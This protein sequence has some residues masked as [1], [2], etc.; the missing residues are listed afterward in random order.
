MET[1][2]G[3]PTVA[4]EEGEIGDVIADKKMDVD[5]NEEALD[6]NNG[7]K[8]LVNVQETENQE[9]Q[10]ESLDSIDGNNEQE[11]RVRVSDTQVKEKRKRGRP[12]K[13]VSIKEDEYLDSNG[14]NTEVKEKRKRGRPKKTDS[15]KKDNVV[16]DAC[17]KNQRFSSRPQR[18]TT[19]TNI[20]YNYWKQRLCINKHRQQ[21]NKR[22]EKDETEEVKSDTTPNVET[23]TTT[24]N[25]E[26]DATPNVETDTTPKVKTGRHMVSHQNGIRKYVRPLMCHQCKRKDK[27]RVVN[28][29]NCKK[30]RYCVPCMTKWYP[31]MTE[32]MFA[33]RCPVC[34]G[35][36]NCKSCLRGVQS[37][38]CHQC[39]HNNKG[40]V[41][42]CGNCKTKRYCVPCMTTWY[43]NMTEEMFAERC[44]VCLGSCN[45]KSCLRDV[46]PNV[47]RKTV[48]KQSADN[49]VQ[50]SI[51]ILHFLLPFL[52]R[53][54]KDNMKEKLI[55]SEV[56]GCRVSDVKLKKA[57]CSLDDRMYCDCCKTSIFDLHRNCPSCN[58]DLCLQCCS[59][60]RDGNPKGNKPEVTAEFID[61]GADYLHGGDYKPVEKHETERVAPK[62][63]IHD[64]KCL[65][66]G[67][68]PCPPK[69]M[70]GCGRGILELMYVERQD[71]VSTLLKNVKELLDKHK[72]EDEEWCT[73]SNSV[74]QND[75]DKQLRKAAFRVDS[76]DNYLYCP[77]AIDIESGDLK[78]FRWHW[79]KGQPV[80]VSNVLE[81]TLGLSWEPMVMWRA[82]RQV[83]NTKHDILL[84][85][86][87]LNCLDWCEVDVSVRHFFNYY[88]DG[89]Y[90][91]NGWP[92]MLKLKDWPP[93]N[94]FEERLPRHCAEFITS[95]P[96]K[97]YTHPS[98]GY[99]NLA[100]KLPEKC[101]KPDVGP[102]TYIAYG[103][104]QELG[105]GDSVTKL[106]CDMSDAV[107]VLT[108]TST[109][110][111]D[112]G[113]LQNIKR[114]K[115]KHKAQDQREL[116][117]PNID[118]TK[119]SEE[120]SSDEQTEDTEVDNQN[121]T[122][123]DGLNL[124]EGGALWDIFRRE[125]TPKLE[126]YLKKHFAEFRH[127]FCCPLNQ[128]IHPIHDQTFYLTVEHKR[129]LKE[130]FGIE[131]WTFVQKLGDA[132][133]IPAGCPH[134]V[135]NLKSCIKV[136]LDF[137][138]PENVGECIRL[139][140]DFRLLPH[141]HRAKEDKLEVKKI[142]LHAV[143][144]AIKE[145]KN[146]NRNE[147]KTEN[148][149]GNTAGTRRKKKKQKI[150]RI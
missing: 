123:V 40:W 83:T 42:N 100:T 29:R 143:D 65:D 117:R 54:N 112:S 75:G 106:H 95:L 91:S 128:V 53:L 113:N 145:L 2:A 11:I 85:V 3:N 114:L 96:F 26:T 24:P 51:H 74:T 126:E 103:V 33:K 137:V 102:K 25:V 127:V 120:D 49:K 4:K 87:A 18:S 105:R 129:K 71:R 132:V 122:C 35:N 138:S 5:V 89:K 31:N 68:I 76:D 148:E 52:E 39:Q 146:T 134:Q 125:D 97:E 110:T 28:C 57:A 80:I 45:C 43:P 67:Q 12:I 111:L 47:E 22:K 119:Q 9:K 59:E 86:S 140:E 58:Y 141:N 50:Y 34:L 144:A 118:N 121:G 84:D 94:L 23:D 135:R 55:E 142:A 139:T 72:L 88:M 116:F 27:C 130:E 98:D 10:D 79:S 149:L 21:S 46:H 16:D 136:G 19:N 8:D 17:V 133:F 81:T 78:H 82:F 32:K 13:T 44:P 63:I 69:S 77:R 64:W 92:Q 37:V 115:R 61:P 15:I 99:L 60:L 124:E 66:G 7:D 93:S 20:C 48:F 101:C 107:N 1:T 147:N 41:V 30:R 131:P 14:G 38:M 90:E 6:L 109:W 36:C 62:K 56:Q 73:C 150:C 70:G 108:D 104:T